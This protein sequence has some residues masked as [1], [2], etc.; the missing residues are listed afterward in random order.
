MS[1]DKFCLQWNSFSENT[2]STFGSLREDT[3]FTDVTLACED[4]YQV[5]THKV[6]LISASPFFL[7]LLKEARVRVRVE[8]KVEMKVKTLTQVRQ[9]VVLYIAGLMPKIGLG[10]GLGLGLG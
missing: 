5:E 10:L 3:D 2:I 4:G 7:N 8:M 9:L 6:I 1:N